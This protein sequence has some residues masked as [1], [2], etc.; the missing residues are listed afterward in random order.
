MHSKHS[1]SRGNRTSP[2]G[3]TW[4]NP[5]SCL[6]QAWTDAE[7]AMDSTN[8]MI[9]NLPRLT[10]PT[11]RIGASRASASTPSSMPEHDE[12]ISQSVS[13]HL[14]SPPLDSCSSSALCDRCSNR[15]AL[16]QPPV[17]AC[18]GAAVW[19]STTVAICR[20]RPQLAAGRTP[21]CEGRICET[22]SQRHHSTTAR[23]A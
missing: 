5:F 20:S 17:K 19:S 1:Q 13:S 14:P 21:L 15:L 6:I 23:A 7:M 2:A 11:V 3:T 10:C 4:A 22:A 9:S 18:R 16:M 8:A 12:S